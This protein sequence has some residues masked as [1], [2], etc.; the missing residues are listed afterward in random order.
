MGRWVRWFGV[1]ETSGPSG[2]YESTGGAMTAAPIADAGPGPARAPPEGLQVAER[3]PRYSP[4]APT[5]IISIERLP[6]EMLT[7]ILVKE[8]V[9]STKAEHGALQEHRATGRPVEEVL[10]GQGAIEEGEL[11]SVLSR[12]CRAPHL[13]LEQYEIRT[14]VLET[15]P[16]EFARANRVIPYERIGKILNVAMSNPLDIS[17]IGRLREQTGLN[18]KPALSSPREIRKCLDRYYPAPPEE[19]APETPEEDVSVS[20]GQIL[21]E[22]IGAGRGKEGP[23]AAGAGVPGGPLQ[24]GAPSG[25]AAVEEPAEL[26]SEEDA[27]AFTRHPSGAFCRAWE[28]EVGFGF[29]GAIWAIPVSD[30]EFALA[31]TDVPMGQEAPADPEP[32]AEAEL[33]TRAASSSKSKRSAKS[34]KGKSG[35]KGKKKRKRK[36]KR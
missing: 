22:V 24:D 28:E 21:R 3:R 15:I 23:G 31:A 6:A 1:E 10:I 4:P 16:A 11:V 8:G 18:V 5:G 20:T 12:K 9:L 34:G 7:A 29:D 36:S 2:A 35:K 26:L 14:E 27:M 19:T 13:N 30:V 25:Q 17:T 32:P 33:E